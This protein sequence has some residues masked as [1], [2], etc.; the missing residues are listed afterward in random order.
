MKTPP[1]KI[2]V[3]TVAR[4][5]APTIAGTLGSIIKQTHPNVE[6]IVV[7]GASTDGT[8]DI[9]KGV[10]S[11]LAGIAAESPDNGKSMKW[12]SETD[13]GLYD[14]MNKGLAMAT[15]DVAGFLNSDDRFHDNRVLARV[16]ET[17]EK[18]AVDCVF[19]NLVYVSHRN[20]Q[21][22]VRKWTGSPYRK[23]AFLKGWHPAHPTF[24]A[25]TRLY[26]RMGG[27]DTTFNISADF[28]LML[29]FFTQGNI[30]SAYI[31]HTLVD[32][33][34]GGMSTRSLSNII[35]GNRN[36]LRAFKKN[37]LKVS[38]LYPFRRL[39]PKAWDIIKNR[40]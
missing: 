39:L 10:A 1:I 18:E 25:R 17:F 40:F 11:Q 3:I 19:G 35:E 34:T 20:P 2:S 36:V 23:G 29:R 5:S 8:V 12:C 32:M 38:V 6:M 14:A 31:P 37:G 33:R 22:I 9:I 27:F 4:N 28:E 16:A 7:D 26:E 30:N 13:A 21:N 24:Y 15:G